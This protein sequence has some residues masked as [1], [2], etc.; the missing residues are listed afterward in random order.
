MAETNAPTIGSI[1]WIDLTVDDAPGIRAFYEDVVGMTHEAAP[2]GD[3]DDYCLRPHDGDPVAGVCHARGSNAEMP[4]Q[5]LIY[6]V[7]A[8]VD[9]SVQRCT[10]RGGAVIV[11]IKSMDGHGRYCVIKDPAGA[12]AALFE[13]AAG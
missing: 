2:M 13:A 11:P 5:W 6:F 10:E 4:P 1:G 9:G 12:V 7:V 3:Y 8:D